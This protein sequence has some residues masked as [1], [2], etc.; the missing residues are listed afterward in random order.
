MNKLRKILIVSGLLLSFSDLTEIT[1]KDTKKKLE[2]RVTELEITVMSIIDSNNNLVRGM[3]LM[4][5]RTLDL[6][7]RLKKYEL[8]EGN[9]VRARR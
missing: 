2:D 7:E 1:A 5:E 4:D 6:N 9:K 8:S 3:E